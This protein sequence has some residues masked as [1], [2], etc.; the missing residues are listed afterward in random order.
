MPLKIHE[1]ILSYL[2]KCAYWVQLF[3]L[4]YTETNSLPCVVMQLKRHFLA[5][6]YFFV[7]LVD[8]TSISLKNTVSIMSRTCIE[9]DSRYY[10][11]WFHYLIFPFAAL[12]LYARQIT[13][14]LH[15]FIIGYN[16]CVS[17]FPGIFLKWNEQFAGTTWKCSKEFVCS[18]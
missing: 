4:N 11:T 2:N 10:S 6:N 12:F 9:T 8:K 18:V 14:G 5:A 13:N 3:V 1:I 17:L 7:T 16:E 15:V